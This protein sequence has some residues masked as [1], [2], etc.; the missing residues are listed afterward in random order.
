MRHERPD[1]H[2]TR[3][4]GTALRTFQINPTLWSANLKPSR[5]T[6]EAAGTPEYRRG[7]SDPQ[8]KSSIFLGA[9]MRLPAAQP[10]SDHLISSW[11]DPPTPRVY[12]PPCSREVAKDAGMPSQRTR[13]VVRDTGTGGVVKPERAMTP[14]QEDCDRDH[15]AKEA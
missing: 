8:P 4:V 7:L 12:D 2:V 11:L 3:H 14:P 10:E 5:R 9:G 13:K 6:D 15:Q 1:G